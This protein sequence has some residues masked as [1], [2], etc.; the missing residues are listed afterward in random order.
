M[1]LLRRPS[2]PILIVLF[3]LTC[4]IA[5]ARSHTAKTSLALAAAVECADDCKERLDAALEKCDQM[6]EDSRDSCRRV[7]NMH[8]EKCLEKCNGKGNRKPY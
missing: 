4:G 3:L 1:K 7:A 5:I 2:L 8:H 6:P